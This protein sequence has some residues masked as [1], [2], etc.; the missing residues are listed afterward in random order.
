MAKP[1]NADRYLTRRWPY[2]STE[3]VY[4]VRPGGDDDNNGLTELTAFATLERALHFMSIAEVNQSVIVDITGMTI[5]ATSVLN[6]GGTTLGGVN[7]DLDVTATSPNNFFS[8]RHRQIRAELQLSQA[9]TVTGS[10]FD[11]TSGILTLTVSTALVAN[12]LR[13]LFAVGAGLGEYGVIRSN[14]GG[15]GP[16]TIE[17]CNTVGLSNPVGAYTTGATMTF[18]DPANFFEQA[19]YLQALCDWTIQGIT[20]TSNGPKA[21]AIG[22]LGCTSV[23]LT[24]CDIAGIQIA[25]RGPTVIDSCLVRDE[26][27]AQ[28]GG[29]VRATQSLFRALNFLCHGNGGDGLNEFVASCFDA[30]NDPFGGGNVESQFNFYVASCEFANNVGGAIQAIGGVSR[31][32]DTVIE[33]NGGSGV[34]AQDGATVTLDN[35]QGSGNVGYGAVVRYGA[36]IKRENASAVTGT[37]DD[38]F[39][40]TVGAAGWGDIPITDLDELARIGA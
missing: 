21:T 2:G 7:N 17:V 32:Q 22:V 25:G 10:S 33:N 38:I 12:A 8:R 1:L 15:A 23:S 18:G 36:Q 19:I 39:V 37:L 6:I 16:N 13:G 35:V 27:Y 24:L 31:V 4:Y 5:N 26:T 34:T 3:I 30:N 9:L 28:D 11:A 40:G 14:T 29:G 20:I